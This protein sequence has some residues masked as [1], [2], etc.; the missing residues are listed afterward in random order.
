MPQRVEAVFRLAVSVDDAG[1]DLEGAEATVRNVG[2]ILDLPVSV[3]EDVIDLAR[4]VPRA[5]QPPAFEDIG[6]QF[7]YRDLAR[8]GRRFRR[9]EL[10]LKIRAAPDPDLALGNIFP[11]QPTSSELRNPA[12][13]AVARIACHRVPSAALRMVLTSALV[14]ISTPIS[15]L[16]FER[17]ALP[18]VTNAATFC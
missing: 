17:E 8:T 11:P 6:E 15:S 16:P 10:V 7:R 14:G 1:A 13:A 3:G 4:P 9:A 2:V 12:R 5:L 18:S